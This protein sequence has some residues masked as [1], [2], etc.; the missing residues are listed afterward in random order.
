MNV[1]KHSKHSVAKIVVAVL[2]LRLTHDLPFGYLG[3]GIYVDSY[4]HFYRIRRLI[5]SIIYLNAQVSKHD[6]TCYLER[7]AIDLV[8]AENR[9]GSCLL[10]LPNVAV[11]RLFR[12]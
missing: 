11:Y 9:T 10:Y 7:H 1:Y 4:V 12:V 8:V 3:I 6:L 5:F 2:L